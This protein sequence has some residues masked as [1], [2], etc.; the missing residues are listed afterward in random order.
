[1]K[2]EKKVIS[3]IP[4]YFIVIDELSTNNAEQF[5]KAS[6]AIPNSGCRFNNGPVPTIIDQ[7]NDTN[8]RSGSKLSGKN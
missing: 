7:C 3:S 6:D 1:M 8:K 4:I 2:V 5:A